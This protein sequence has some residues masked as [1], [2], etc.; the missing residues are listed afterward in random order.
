[1]T[2]VTLDGLHVNDQ[3]N[4]QA[5][6]SSVNTALALIQELNTTVAGGDS[7]FGTSAGGPLAL[8]TKSGTNNFH[9]QAFDFNRLTA[10]AANDY[11]NT[12]QGIP[13][14]QLIRNQFGGDLG[15]PIV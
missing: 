11:F 1:Q 8:V 15:G 10:L 3:R 13:N 2:N 4:G 9:G 7:T 6:V 5:F 14:P 12:L